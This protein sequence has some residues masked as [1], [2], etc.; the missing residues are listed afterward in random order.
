MQRPL[1][2][3]GQ[4]L[5]HAGVV[6]LNESPPNPHSTE[7]DLTKKEGWLGYWAIYNHQLLRKQLVPV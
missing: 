1:L 5:F 7:K 2:P 3:F 4:N 6:F